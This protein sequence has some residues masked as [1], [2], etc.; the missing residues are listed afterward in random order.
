MQITKP[1][2]ASERS[3]NT[4]TET[5][6]LVRIANRFANHYPEYLIEAWALGM[7]MVSACVFTIWF[8]HPD[9]W[10]RQHVV[11]ADLR[12]ALIGI[13]M[14]CTA[15][16]LIY[17]PWGKR[18]GAHMN[19][20]VTLTFLRLRKIDPIDAGFYVL[21]QCAGALTGVLTA[22]A[23]FGDRIA[24]PAVAYAV[25]TPGTAGVL[26]AFLAECGIAF[27][28]MSMVLRVGNST[29]FANYTG[30]CAGVMV[31]VFI[32]FEAPLSG[33]SMNPARSLASAVPAQQWLSFW[34][35]LLAPVVGMNLAASVSLWARG[36]DRVHCAKLLHTKDQR[37]IHCGYEPA[38]HRS[39][40]DTGVSS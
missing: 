13:A 27:L 33:M 23:L 29:N 14:G 4:S 28:M 37:C 26:I 22:A 15:I 35:Y 7:F 32:T 20:A 1:L 16:V 2:V 31:A 18:S 30:I 12:R 10:L 25:T 17:S 34:I 36:H 21:A 8:E 19:P 39:L 24:H 38:P 11:N 9:S 3:E 6:L 40:L 5:R